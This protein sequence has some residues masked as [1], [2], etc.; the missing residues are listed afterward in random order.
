MTETPGHLIPILVKLRS[1]IKTIAKDDDTTPLYARLDR[2]VQEMIDTSAG[3]LPDT[4]FD[5]LMH[6]VMAVG[7]EEL[8][9][10]YTSIQYAEKRRE[11][12]VR[13]EWAI[14]NG[15]TLDISDMIRDYSRIPVRSFDWQGK[16]NAFNRLVARMA[17]GECTYLEL[18][19]GFTNFFDRNG[20]LFQP[21]GFPAMTNALVSELAARRLI[22]AEDMIPVIDTINRIKNQL[23]V[24][25]G[26]AKNDFLKGRMPA[27]TLG[28]LKDCG[29]HLLE[30]TCRLHFSTASPDI[31]ACIINWKEYGRAAFL[32]RLW[33][34]APTETN[35]LLILG[36]SGV[37]PKTAPE[38]F[39]DW[40]HRES[41]DDQNGASCLRSLVDSNRFFYEL[42]YLL[43][44]RESLGESFD[45]C[46]LPLFTA[47][48][49][50]C[51]RKGEE[52]APPPE[53]VA[54]PQENREVEQ[55][56]I[57]NPM[58]M[59]DDDPS[60]SLPL[61]DAH[62]LIADS[63]DTVFSTDILAGNAPSLSDEDKLIEEKS[64]WNRYL[65]P[66]L[67]ENFLGVLG[68]GFL[69]LAW[70]C[71]SVWV[72]DRGQY[73][74]LLAGAL[75]MYATTLGLGWI[76]RFFHNNLGRGVSPKAPFLF[77]ALCILTL[78]FNYLIALSMMLTGSTFG[79]IIG[80]AMAAIYT[81]TIK[82]MSGGFT[83][84]LG[85]N[86]AS[87][88]SEINA[89]LLMPALFAIIWEPVRLFSG[90]VILWCIAIAY[91]RLLYNTRAMD[92]LPSRVKFHFFGANALLVIFISCVYMRQIPTSAS[93]AL[94]VQST[95]LLVFLFR[96]PHR[97]IFTVITDSLLS[98]SAILIAIS[99]APLALIPCLLLTIGLWIM[100]KKELRLAW[101]DEIVA[102]LI[103][104]LCPAIL[105]TWQMDWRLAGFLF[106]P[107]TMAACLYE[108]RFSSPGDIRIISYMLPLFSLI[109]V[110][111]S[112]T[113][114]VK[115]LFHGM[116]LLVISLVYGIYAIYRYERAY[117][118]PLWY[119][120][121]GLSI[122][123]PFLIIG[124]H[125]S[126][127]TAIALLSSAILCHGLVHINLKA[128]LSYQYGAAIHWLATSLVS[129]LFL[130]ACVAKGQAHTAMAFGYIM[131]TCSLTMAARS[132]GSMLPVFLLLACSGAF[133]SAIF[134]LLGISF[135]TGT[136][137]AVTAVV[138]LYASHL[139]DRFSVWQDRPSPHRF[140]HLPYPMNTPKFLVYPIE[141]AAWV[142][143]GAAFFKAITHHVFIFEN[144]QWQADGIKIG[145]TFSIV[146]Y[147]AIRFVKRYGLK[148]SGYIILIPALCLYAGLIS[149][150]PPAW[151]PIAILVSMYLL[152]AFTRYVSRAGNTHPEIEKALNHF[153][154]LV[155]Q[156]IIPAGF[157]VY[158]FYFRLPQAIGS[159]RYQLALSSLLISVY[160]H[161]TG[162]RERTPKLI[163]IILC[164]LTLII[165][166]AYLVAD[167][168]FLQAIIDALSRHEGMMLISSATSFL[169]LMLILS[170]I[171]AVPAYLLEPYADVLKKE[172]SRTLHI[173][174]FSITLGYSAL[175]AA[176]L[177]VHG[178]SLHP[179]YMAAGILL[180]H[181]GN[182][183][184]SFF[185]LCFLKS[186]FCLL[187]GISVSGAP[188]TGMIG[189]MALFAA[190]EFVAER[191]HRLPAL[192]IQ[193]VHE[194]ELQLPVR[195]AWVIHA[196]VIVFLFAHMVILTRHP[197]TTPPYL[198]YTMIPFSFFVYR[199]L[200]YPYTG[201]IANGLFAYGNGVFIL[202]FSP[203]LCVGGLNDI[204]LI[205][206]AMIFSIL[207]YRGLDMATTRKRSTNT[208]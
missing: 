172:Y 168:A 78:P 58:E 187:T 133:F 180:V 35:A 126:L 39:N 46:F 137:T 76:S 83:A 120:E 113:S 125:L 112:L 148:R 188:L 144:G 4:D 104:T 2:I 151:L 145:L 36:C 50:Q 44:C 101:P 59:V 179:A 33:R 10:V 158:A 153:L 171:Y 170:V 47:F 24:D 183:Y 173:W 150:V 69:M 42:G 97:L 6:Q 27:D 129:I 157:M 103:L 1:K 207:F 195:T 64:A 71:I 127:H 177:T 7:S 95:A 87:H 51:L 138:F 19:D 32:H 118:K 61:Q 12:L 204:H 89:Y 22:S 13:R 55:R 84:I 164:H 107:A 68:A 178:F 105:Y 99:A 25:D 167:K 18:V 85:L 190:I 86:P 34:H 102:G 192:R 131:I 132:S 161:I 92:K 54:P 184:F 62:D 200:K 142:L 66:F 121:N 98:L 94:F 43:S 65:K 31:T 176:E 143:A 134:H 15:S 122:L 140:F 146:L 136:G 116:V 90:D 77:A 123:F 189:G 208:P 29:Y 109:P 196:G 117:R 79:M 114:P 115:P 139:L 5:A 181:L 45:T 40:V 53:I 23:H 48:R 80:I 75:P 156:A 3:E 185:P 63:M 149:P 154:F 56:E 206:A 130:L 160:I 11:I 93:M 166:L 162:V 37:D 174:L 182:R 26:R 8:G 14:R 100:H 193:S 108:R 191:L 74:R 199:H 30:K 141:I 82:S 73:Y 111:I 106:I 159:Y 186:G 9:E 155:N 17:D 57:S 16:I 81:I 205:C 38:R 70:F 147:M 135:K 163:H 198:I 67:S 20:S 110:S 91:G 28:T 49:D 194:K 41:R 202:H 203:V 72:W 128:P 165:T 52:A 175:I 88:L 119:I 96:K 152:S 197:Y 169:N 201:Y 124:I 60:L 21:S